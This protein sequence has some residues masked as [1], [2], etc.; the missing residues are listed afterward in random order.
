MDKILTKEVVETFFVILVSFLIYFILKQ[1]LNKFGLQKAKEHGN[2]KAMTSI[3]MFS[4]VFKYI[5]LIFSFLMILDVWGVDTKALLTSLGIVGVAAGLAIQ[6]LLKD[7]ISGTSIVTEN[8]FKVGDYI[9]IG[10]FKGTVIYLGMKT[11]KIKGGCGEVKII[12]N[13]NITEVI[14]YTAMPYSYALDITV[15]YANDLEK[16]ENVLKKVCETV[17][18]QVN[19]LKKPIEITGLVN[20]DSNGVTYRVIAELTPPKNYAFKN[21]FLTEVKKEFE[22]NNLSI[23][24]NRMDVHNV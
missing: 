7:F 10:D 24:Y 8:Q 23:S 16:V 19:Y 21:L 2:K 15:S 20:M 5:I 9:Q 13:R 14:N 1:T 4:N 18:K 3:T 6:D 12:S 11:T 22:A 17:S